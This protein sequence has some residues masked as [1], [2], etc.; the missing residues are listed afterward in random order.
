MKQDWKFHLPKEIAETLRGSHVA[1][2][3]T[4]AVK[5]DSETSH[6]GRCV[7]L[8][9]SYTHFRH[10]GVMGILYPT[11]LNSWEGTSHLVDY[12]YHEKKPVIITTP[13]FS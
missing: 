2:P 11:F 6:G 8:Y 7:K 5:I 4:P 9:T 10:F 13:S 3:V 1:I 12:M